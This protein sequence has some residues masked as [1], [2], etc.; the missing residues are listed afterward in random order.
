MIMMAVSEVIIN[1]PGPSMMKPSVE[2]SDDC[3]NLRQDQVL[4]FTT[5]PKNSF[6]GGYMDQALYKLLG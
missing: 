5:V 1:C 3:A 6:I 2:F 4:S